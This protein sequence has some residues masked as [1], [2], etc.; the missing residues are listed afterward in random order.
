[1][2]GAMRL[3]AAVSWGPGRLDLFWLGEANDLWHRT[4]TEGVW[5]EPESLGGNL[6]SGPTVT[7]WGGDRMEVFA[8]FPDGQLWDRYWDGEAWHEWK[9]LE[10]DLVGQ[11][12][13]SS[14]GDDRL[15]VF[16]PGRDPS[17]VRGS[18]VL[19]R[20]GRGG[21]SGR[22]CRPRPASVRS[23]HGSSP[24]EQR[25]RRPFALPTPT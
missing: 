6:A 20:G 12:A 23:R 7:A 18:R 25:V 3:P 15:D 11:P 14:W 19:P 16:A 5:A 13:A 8:I 17:P 1:M 22:A 4:M 21:V 10:G 24:V 2:D 9:T